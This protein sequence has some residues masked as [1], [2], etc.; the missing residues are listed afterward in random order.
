MKTKYLLVVGACAGLFTKVDHAFA[1]NWTLTSAPITNWTS[2]ASSA[3]G[4]KLA[5]VIGGGGIY[6]SPDSG[7]TWIAA[8]VPRTNWQAVACSTDGA[9]LVAVVNGGGIFISTNSGV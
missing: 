5:A 6:T 3:D 9:K 1:Q 2:V 8:S 4:S 7:A